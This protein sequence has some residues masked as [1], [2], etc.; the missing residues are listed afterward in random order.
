MRIGPV[1]SS[2]LRPGPGRLTGGGTI[3]RGGTAV[4]TATAS[5]TLRRALPDDAAAIVRVN[6]EP[7]VLAN[8]LQVPYASVEA[9]RTR[10]AEQQ[11]PGRTDL[12]L[13]AELGGEVVGCAGLHPAGT[14]LRRRHVMGLGIGVAR[15]AQGRGVGK[16][17]MAAM[18]DWADRWGHVTRI[19]LCVFIDNERAIAL[20]RRFDFRVEG[21]LRA[22]ALRDGV[23]A[24]VFAMARLHPNPPRLAWPED[25]A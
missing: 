12:Q 10:L 9:M 15:A 7:D 23:Y 24:D 1:L 25:A 6:S 3:D 4:A 20:Y 2:R 11:Q 13:V 14:Q 16:A 22:F 21:T 5:I 18:C 19:E 8:L 17:L